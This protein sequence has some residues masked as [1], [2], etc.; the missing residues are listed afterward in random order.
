VTY[1]AIG[2]PQDLLE[3][4][5]NAGFMKVTGVVLKDVMED[6][7]LDHEAVNKGEDPFDALVM[8]IIIAVSPRTTQAQLEAILL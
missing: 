6:L 3:H 1:H 7:G 8:H 4:Q 2:E 5:A